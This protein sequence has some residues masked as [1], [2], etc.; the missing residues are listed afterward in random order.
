MDLQNLINHLKIHLA[1]HRE[2]RRIYAELDSYTQREM[3]ADLG[4]NRSEIPELAAMAADQHVNRF[5]R[6]QF[7]SHQTWQ[8]QDYRRLAHS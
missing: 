2:Y 6:P 7:S 5:V 3:K 4:L 1:W 8:I